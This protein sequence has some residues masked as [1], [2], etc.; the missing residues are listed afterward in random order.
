MFIRKLTKEERLRIR[1]IES[2]VKEKHINLE[3]HDYSHVL[4]VTQFAIDIANDVEEEVDPIILI[5]GAL[6]HDIG[7][8]VSNNIHGL[9]GSS[10]AEELL[11]SL[12]FEKGQIKRITDIIVRHTP[13]S[14]IPPQRMEEKIVFDADALDQLGTMGLLRGF[15]GKKGS[16]VNVLETYMS[17]REKAY[18]KL[19]FPTSQKIGK[20]LDEEMK[21]L[22]TLFTKRLKERKHDVENIL[23]P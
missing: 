1:Q 7:R 6:L 5:C 4:A 8:T 18:D 14:H 16:M 13:T 3:S 20:E 11:E 2:F 21:I 15:I 9:V 12:D 17:K 19:Y 10:I 22:I 23:L